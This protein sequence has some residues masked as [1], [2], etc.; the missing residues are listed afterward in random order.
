MKMTTAQLLE[1]RRVHSAG[2]IIERANER[3]SERTLEVAR[4]ERNRVGQRKA[5][6]GSNVRNEKSIG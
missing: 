2:R 6:Q 1:N 4:A 5:S 3:T